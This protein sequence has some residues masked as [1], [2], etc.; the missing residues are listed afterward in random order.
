MTLQTLHYQADNWFATLNA[1]MDNSQT[2]MIL[3]ASGATGAPD[4]PFY[5]NV[6]SEKMECTNVAADTPSGGLDTLTVVRGVLGSSPTTHQTTETPE[7]CVYAESLN[8]PA[9]RLRALEALVGDMLGRGN[10]VQKT[11]SDDNLK[12]T[13]KTPASLIVDVGVGVGLVDQ[14]PVALHDAETITFVPETVGW[15]R[16]DVIYINQESELSQSNG[17]P[18]AA[19]GT[20]SPSGEKPNAMKLAHVFVEGG[21]T[22]IETADIT[23]QRDFL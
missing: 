6:G 8:A 17:T 20:G 4:T 19:P 3:A 1:A 5:L 18:V 11:F 21:T 13:Q 9:A 16:T 14:Q 7:Q 15:N 10:G 23:D 2:T 12:V 22:T